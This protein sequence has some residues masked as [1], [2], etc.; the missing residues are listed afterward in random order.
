KVVATDGAASDDFGIAVSGLSS[1]TFAV[2][3]YQDTV[4]GTKTGSVYVFTSDS[5]GNWGQSDQV[6]ASDGAAADFFGYAVSGLGSSTLAVGAWGD[7]D[8]GASSGSVYVFT[9]NNA[10]SSWAQS[11]KIIASDG[12]TTTLSN[13]RFG[14]A[15]SGLSNSILAVSASNFNFELEGSVYVFT[16]SNGASWVQLT[17]VTQESGVN[18]GC[19]VSGLSSSTFVVGAYGDEAEYEGAV[20]VFT[21]DGQSWWQ[22]GNRMEASDGAVGDYFGHA[23]SGLSNR[24]FAVGAYYYENDDVV[25]TGSVYVFTR[26]GNSW[27][28]SDKVV[29]SDG[30]SDDLFGFAVSGLG[31]SIFAVGA[32]NNDDMGADSGSAYVFTSNGT[33]SSW[34]QSGN[35][36]ASDGE[37]GDAFGRAV[38][39][40]SSSILAVGAYKDDSQKGS[41]YVF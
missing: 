4:D 38:S 3:A 1:S 36:V 30:A 12:D 41:A 10:G 31:S 28:Q 9:S 7:D 40:L 5:N 8:K 33:G 21:T 34:V 37:A 16:R 15:V 39:G 2:G 6:V 29:A 32:H 18:F 13:D 26:D 11:D 20:Y 25:G 27:L 23:V 24:T 22:Q 17:K 14:R 19:A 35:V